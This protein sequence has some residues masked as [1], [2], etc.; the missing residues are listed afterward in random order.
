[1]T[2]VALMLSVFLKHKNSPPPFSLAISQGIK[3][4]FREMG[5]SVKNKDNRA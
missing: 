5:Y 4:V 2:L 3:D 1:M